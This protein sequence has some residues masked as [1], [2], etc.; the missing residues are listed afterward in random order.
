MHHALN[1][2]RAGRV[3]RHASLRAIS[4]TMSVLSLL[5]LLISVVPEMITQQQQGKLAK[6]LV[7]HERE[8]LQAM[9]VFWVEKRTVGT[10]S[11]CP[12]RLVDEELASNVSILGDE[13]DGMLTSGQRNWEEG[14]CFLL[15]LTLCHGGHESWLGSSAPVLGVLN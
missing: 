9:E 8:L 1:I 10:G 11:H 7:A 6:R 12:R 13:A 2:F 15:F 4:E 5:K 14:R 3:S